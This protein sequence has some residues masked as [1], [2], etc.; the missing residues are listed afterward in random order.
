[1]SP[2]PATIAY[3]TAGAAGMYC[4]SCMHDNTLARALTRR[5]VD[6]QLIPTYTPIRTDEENVAIDRVF[7]GGISVFGAADA[8]SY[9]FLVEGNTITGAGPTSASADLRGI[10]IASR[11]TGTVRNN[12][13]SGFSYNGEGAELP[14]GLENLKLRVGR[15]L[16]G[17]FRAHGGL[18][19]SQAV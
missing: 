10:E 2:P 11:V 4:G 13:A 17:S 8:V 19:L 12:S 1:M 16:A 18:R 3:L 5:G 6:I 9:D 7:Y 15:A 14:E